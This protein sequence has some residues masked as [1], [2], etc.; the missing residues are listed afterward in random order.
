MASFLLPDVPFISPYV[1]EVDMLAWVRYVAPYCDRVEQ[2]V[3]NVD[4]LKRNVTE[5]D[6][7]L[8]C[9]GALLVE[10]IE[11]A[12]GTISIWLLHLLRPNID[13]PPEGSDHGE[14]IIVDVFNQTSPLV[15]GIRFNI[16]PF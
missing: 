13:S 7:W 15:S 3:F 11:H 6:S 14:V 16:D 8:S 1:N 9:A 10:R 12:A 5:G 4:I 2:A